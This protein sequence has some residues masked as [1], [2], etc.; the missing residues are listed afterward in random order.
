[1]NGSISQ[2][3][4]FGGAI[5]CDLPSGLIDASDLRQIPDN[6]EVLL[7]PDSNIT[8][9]IE[10]L[11]CVSDQK[12]NEDIAR[13]HFDSLAHDNDASQ[14]NILSIQEGAS[15]GDTPSPIILKGKQSIH[16][17]NNDTQSDQ[18]LIHVAIWRLSPRKQIDIV[19]S[20]NEPLVEE[21]QQVSQGDEKVEQAFQKAVKSFNIKDWSLFA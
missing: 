19:M 13:F 17:F 6:Q 20:W 1:M 7:S 9:I 15:Q 3:E 12:T 5:T 21:G 2:R 8:H 14:S 16:K 18:V 10:I 11:E 4:L